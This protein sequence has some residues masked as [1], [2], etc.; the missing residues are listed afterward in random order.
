MV[1]DSMSLKRSSFSIWMQAIRPF[2]FPASLVPILTG[3]ALA[4]GQGDSPLWGL[5]PLV[6]ICGLLYHTATNLISDYFDWIKGVDKDY[7]FGSSRVIVEGWLS[8]QQI[9]KG[10]WIAFGVAVGLGFILIFYRGWP[11][12]LL[13][14]VGLLGGYLYTGK[15]L[16]FKYIALGDI[17]VFLLMGPLMALGSYYSITGKLALLPVYASLPIGL[18]TVAI[19]HANNTRDIRHDTQAGVKTLASLIGHQASRFYYL[20]LVGAAF[21]LVITLV[22]TRLLPLFSLI[23]LISLP[24]ALKNISQMLKAQA[25]RSEEI[26]M[27][28]IR[29]AQHHLLFG[30]LLILS[31]V[32]GK[33]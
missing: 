29:T 20:G 2:A 30:I 13:G 28:D 14:L 5:A 4:I 12:F 10:G 3:F 16:G 23:V 25:E 8:P 1:S 19:L 7:T 21:G 11:I 17:G 32:A 26:A 33:L 15:P 9:L 27:L 18:L 31:I 24:M 6:L 22:A